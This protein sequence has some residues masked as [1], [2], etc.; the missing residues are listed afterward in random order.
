M[1]APLNLVKVSGRSVP[2]GYDPGPVDLV[3]AA[4]ALLSK[5]QSSQQVHLPR[6][7][8]YDR[9]VLRPLPELLK[10]GPPIFS[11]E[12]ALLELCDDFVHQIYDDQLQKVDQIYVAVIS[13]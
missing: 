4:V 8:S 2:R 11:G 3:V 5:V 9:E 10:C 6:L 12:D 13:S 1:V 7:R